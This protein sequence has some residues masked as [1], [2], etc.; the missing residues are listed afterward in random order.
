MPVT[1]YA[2]GRVSEK[3]WLRRILLDPSKAKMASLNLTPKNPSVGLSHFMLFHCIP[4]LAFSGG[5]V[6]QCRQ[7]L[8]ASAQ[9]D[10]PVLGPH[11]LAAWS[12]TLSHVLLTLHPPSEYPLSISWSRPNGP[13][14]R[15]YAYTYTGECVCLVLE[16]MALCSTDSWHCCIFSNWPRSLHGAMPVPSEP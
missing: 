11:P 4:A 16:N 15:S 10:C 12:P 5:A 14:F 7:I 6:L 9:C 1:F 3:G 13:S 2:A 8:Q